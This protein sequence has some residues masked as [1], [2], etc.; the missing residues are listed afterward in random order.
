[1][2]T[3]Q[4][5]DADTSASSRERLSHGLSDLW[6]LCNRQTVFDVVI[7]GS[8][9]GGSVAA[10]ELANK[11]ITEGEATRPLSICVLERGKEYLP[12]EFPSKFSE[13][14]AHLR[15]GHQNT[16]QVG[17]IHEGLFDVRLGDDVMALVANGVGGGSLINAGVLL[18]PTASHFPASDPMS[19]LLKALSSGK[20]FDRAR[21]SLGGLVTRKNNKG[22]NYAVL[23]TIARHSSNARGPLP[24]TMALQSLTAKLPFE[25]TP[26]SVAMDNEPNSAGVKLNECNLCGDCMTGC[27]VGAKDSLDANLLETATR[28]GVSIFSGASVLSLR[29]SKPPEPNGLWVLRVTHTDPRLQARELEPLYVQARK[30]ILAAGTLGSTEILLRSRDQSLVFSSRLG[31]RFSCNGDNIAAAYR[32]PKRTRGCG[33]EDMPLGKRGVG[34]TI[35]G[36]IANHTGT[37]GFLVQEFSVPGPMKRLFEEIVTTAKVLNELPESDG[38]THGNEPPTRIDPLAVSEGDI[39]RTLLVGIIGHDDAGGTLHLP[40]PLRPLDR[41]AQQGTLRIR[42]PEA[43]RAESLERA[44]SKL[45]GMVASVKARSKP[46][47]IANPMWR[48]LPEQLANLVSQPRGPVLT[49]HPLGGCPIGSSHAD[50]VVDEYGQ[51]FD[52]LDTSNAKPGNNSEALTRDSWFGSLVVLDGSIFPGSLGV[53]PALTITATAMRAMDTLCAGWKFGPKSPSKTATQVTSRRQAP[54]NAGA[55]ANPSPTLPTPT[56]I[57]I[58]ERLRGP[59]AL[60]IGWTLPRQC[61]VELTL[62]YEAIAVRSLMSTI[63]RTLL[64]DSNNPDSRIRVYDRGEYEQ[65]QLRFESDFVRSKAALFEAQIEGELRFLHREPSTAI[66]RR[67]RSIV[68]WALNRGFRDIAQELRG[69]TGAKS[70]SVCEYASSLWKLASRAGEVRRFDYDLRVG[71]ILRGLLDDEKKPVDLIPVGAQIRGT[72]RLTYNRRANPWRQLTELSLVKMPT[73]REERAP[74]LTLDVRFLANQGFPLLRVVKQQDHAKAL[75]DL[76]SFGLYMARVLIST[77]LWTFRKPDT[78]TLAEPR[79]LPGTIAGLEP[80][81]ITE[82]VVDRIPRPCDAERRSTGKTGHQLDCCDSEPREPVKIRLTRYLPPKKATPTKVQETKDAYPPLRPLVMIHGYSVSGNTFTHESLSP[83]AAEFFCRQGREVWVVDLRTSTGLSTATYPWSMEQVGLVDIPAALLHIRNATQQ[84]VDVLAH[85]IGCAMLSMALLTD[86]RDVRSSR[87]Q[88][89]VDT[90]LTSEH[91]GILTAFNGPEPANAGHP[92]VNRIILSQKGPVLRYTDSNVFRAFVMQSAR[93]WLLSDGYQFRPPANP[94]VSDQ[95]LDRLLSSVPYP[96]DDYDVENPRWP[97]KLTPWTATRH[98]M[99]ALY[100]RDFSATNL[101][102]AT[103]AAIDD[104]FGPISLDTVSQTIHFARFHSI[105]NQSGR[106]EF[107]TRRRLRERWGQIPTLAI[108]G[109]QNGLVDASTQNLLDQHLRDAGVPFRAISSDTAPYY[110]LGHQDVLIGKDSALV[111]QDI[112][113]FLRETPAPVTK[114]PD[115]PVV[116]IPWLGPRI[117]L[118][119][120]RNGSL[121]IACMSRPDQGRARLYL[122]PTCKTVTQNSPGEVT[123]TVLVAQGCAIPGDFGDNQHWLFAAPKL[124][125]FCATGA[126][127]GELGYLALLVYEGDESS[128]IANPDWPTPTSTPSAPRNSQAPN[129]KRPAV[130]IRNG[131]WNTHYHVLKLTEPLSQLDSAPWSH[132][133]AEVSE[134]VLSQPTEVQATLDELTRQVA[135]WVKVSPP[136]VM[137]DAFIGLQCLQSADLHKSAKLPSQD[138]AFAVASCQYPAGLLDKEVAGASLTLLDSARHDRGTHIDFVLLVG[139]QIYADATAGLLDPVRRDELYDQ[140]HD[141]AL[142]ARSMRKVLRTVPVRMLLDDHELSDNWE[143]LPRAVANRRPNDAA[144]NSATLR[145]GFGAWRKYQRM[146][147]ARELSQPA[148]PADQSFEYAGYP[149]YFA[150]TRTGRSARGSLVPRV[151]QEI[152]S[153]TQI[154]DLKSWMVLHRESVK[155]VSTPSLLLPRRRST[156]RDLYGSERSDAWDGFP[157]SLQ[158]LLGFM[159]H[160]RVTN[161]VFLSGDEHHSLFSEIWVRPTSCSAAPIKVVSVHSSALYAPFPFANGH[162]IDLITGQDD[163]ALGPLEVHVQSSLAPRGDGFARIA[164]TTKDGCPALNIQ[165]FSSQTTT[166]P[167]AYCVKLS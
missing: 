103:L 76:F 13:L 128:M 81:E 116:A 122:F 41:P 26:I 27:N 111:F 1:M 21:R 7:V 104:L 156:A 53:N 150:D 31:E 131:E 83:S 8:G 95:L 84:Q 135:E 40:R 144:K 162:P 85:C 9:Y 145:N 42:W 96:D 159:V 88:L 92:C 94:T 165:F 5:N 29:R 154:T 74:L 160:E 108:H 125:Q 143:P 66:T 141:K 114:A 91:L 46:T 105:T 133:F 12:G 132:R 102:E 140:P 17:G 60:H 149:F 44:H 101:S 32:L 62:A 126:A 59:V 78:P 10:S 153:Q 73:M 148:G 121:R 54:L 130:G 107:V 70:Q 167:T 22:Q 124:L 49:V 146:R 14:P 118:P 97:C 72:K 43:R 127:Q 151:S 152:L 50:G 79:R 147:L 86:A 80:P 163:F 2:T 20:Y 99:D 65:K 115:G 63:G 51:V 34:P 45:A 15:I 139:D 3:D 16:G 142:R 69:S 77:H 110:W 61:V 23:N 36:S 4:K 67:L 82:L 136:D 117:D 38:R 119:D 137:A 30:V 64:V 158:D 25:L 6:R 129:P 35:T 11:Q 52:A 161:T 100:G 113:D 71:P 24:K 56:T 155:F 87:V 112:E 106:G 55:S 68:A 120:D 75:L 164:V 47:L 134:V 89:G 57:E 48:L 28:G 19:P 166:G 93:R 37:R 39:Q 58:V 109:K 98:R 138:F 33:D 18:E 157:Q 123:Y 90:W